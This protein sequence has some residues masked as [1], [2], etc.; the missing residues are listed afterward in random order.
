MDAEV[1]AAMATPAGPLCAV[2]GD[3]ASGMRGAI[4]W[5]VQLRWII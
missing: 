4:H 5:Y 2:C 3:E 1:A